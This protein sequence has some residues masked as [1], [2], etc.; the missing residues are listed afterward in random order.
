MSNVEPHATALITFTTGSTGTPK[1]ADR[2]HAF[3]KEQFNALLDEIKP[4][5]NDVDMPVLPIVLFVNL[6]VG[7]TSVIADFNVAEPNK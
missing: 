6:G 7:C 1:A 2:S 3:L 5:A 4:S